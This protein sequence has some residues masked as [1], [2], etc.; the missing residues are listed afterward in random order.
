CTFHTAPSSCRLSVYLRCDKVTT[1]FDEAVLVEAGNVNIEEVIFCIPQASVVPHIRC[2]E[3]QESVSRV[4]ANILNDKGEVLHSLPLEIASGESYPVIPIKEIAE[5]TWTLQLSDE[6]GVELSRSTFTVPAPKQF[7]ENRLNNFVS[8]IRS[9][10]PARITSEEPL[11]FVN[12]R[13]GW[14]YIKMTAAEDGRVLFPKATGES[15]LLSAGVATETMRFYPAGECEIATE[16]AVELSQCEIRTVPELMFC[17]YE[18]MA[19]RQMF[20]GLMNSRAVKEFWNT[21]NV[22][23]EGFDKGQT[24]EREEL[25]EATR[26]RIAEWRAT[27]RMLISH[28]M[29]PDKNSKTLPLEDCFE[30]WS[31]RVGVNDYDGIAIDEFGNETADEL[32]AY[33]AAVKKFYGDPNRRA[34]HLY[35]DS[36]AAWG[37]HEKSMDFRK[38][39]AMGSGVYSPEYYLREKWTQGEAMTYINFMFDYLREWEKI[40]PDSLPRIMILLSCTDGLPGYYGQDTMADACYKYFLDMQYQMLAVDPAFDG[41]R[42]IS[43]WILRY[44]RPETIAW[45]AML[46][47]HYC[48]DG[49]TDLLSERLGLTYSLSH[50]KNPDFRNGANGWTLLPAA[51]GAMEVVSF[52]D[53]GFGRGT[54]NTAP[55]GDAVMLMKRVAGKGNMLKQTVTG[56]VPGQWYELRMRVADYDDVKAG[57]C[58]R[59]LLPLT[60]ALDGVAWAQDLS[61]IDVYQ[62]DHPMAPLYPKYSEGACANEL[63]LYFKATSENA[64]LTISDEGIMEKIRSGNYVNAPFTVPPA[65]SIKTLMVNFIQLQ[66]VLP[67]QMWQ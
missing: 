34:K 50:V 32:P 40:T 46:N 33:T 2:G 66:P 23:L 54:C 48:I 53:W 21:T 13:Q 1:Y 17:E 28:A 55:D 24:M 59:K 57:K 16:E 27:G 52:K 35:T 63:Q 14:I 20:A 64:I 8:V 22:V 4:T 30:Y 36:C 38:A 43:Q 18:G 25:P 15:L 39:L 65:E 62:S 19:S 67:P 60:V 9:N 41:L 3:K 56:L 31:S 49:N 61:F 42:G 29:R 10:A 7:P 6:T 44:A 37:S 47:R 51:E 58:E 5:G 11:S 45:L 12:P 26:K